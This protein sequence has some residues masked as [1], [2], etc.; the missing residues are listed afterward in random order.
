MTNTDELHIETG[1]HGENSNIYTVSH[2]SYG[3]ER[4]DSWK[5]L[6]RTRLCQEIRLRRKHWYGNVTSQATDKKP[7]RASS[8][9]CQGANDEKESVQESRG[10]EKIIK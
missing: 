7:A 10:T 5:T 1:Q 2:I 9:S 3:T 6:Q 4:I 8:E